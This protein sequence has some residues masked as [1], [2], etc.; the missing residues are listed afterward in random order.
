MIPEFNFGDQSTAILVTASIREARRQ[1]GLSREALATRLQ[2]H[3][4]SSRPT[5]SPGALD[6]G[7]T[8]RAGLRSDGPAD[9]A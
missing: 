1:L 6:A 7:K 9:S 3:G 5:F 4:P 8:A 2:R